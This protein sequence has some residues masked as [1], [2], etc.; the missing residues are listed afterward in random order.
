M[1]RHAKKIQSKSRTHQVTPTAHKG[2]FEV[3]SGSS[4]SQYYV[5]EMTDGTFRC[6]CKWAKYH[7]GGECSHTTSVREHLAQ[8]GSRSIEAWS[9]ADDAKR[10]HHRSE[11]ANE[12][13]FFTSRKVTA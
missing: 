5:Q 1:N 3:T 8:A 2:V 13:V 6:N 9:S 4:G 7:P 10:S 11:G 12:G